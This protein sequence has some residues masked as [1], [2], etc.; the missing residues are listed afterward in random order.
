MSTEQ[1]VSLEN[2]PLPSQGPPP[3]P[4][5]YVPPTD[6]VTLPSRGILYPL[7]SPFHGIEEVDIRS[8]TARE[9]DILSSPALLKSGRAIS[10]LLRSCLVQTAVDPD[11]LLVGDRNALLVAIRI[12]GYGRAYDPEVECPRCETRGKPEPAF[13]LAKMEIK[14]L[15][16]QPIEAGT[17]AFSYRLPVSGLDVVF[18]LLTGADE[19]ELSN[20]IERQRKASGPLGI[21]PSV[22]SRLWMHCISIGGET[23]RNKLMGIIR[24]LSPRDSRALR[25]HIADIEPGIRMQQAFSCRACGEESEVD[26]PMTVS[27]F[28]PSD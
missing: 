10:T 3:Q 12:T 20:I 21:D 18:R 1:R 16:A 11:S 15:G 14:R 6:S 5:P 7:D 26:V 17:N 25:K 22:T 13:D 23:D 27:F 24:N 28:W 4:Q 19:R 2:Q 8:M 9:E